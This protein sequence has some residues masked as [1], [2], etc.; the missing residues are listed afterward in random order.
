[1]VETFEGKRSARRRRSFRRQ[2][3]GGGATEVPAEPGAEGGGAEGG[4]EEEFVPEPGRCV[5]NCSIA[6]YEA[7]PETNNECYGKILTVS[8]VN[9][10]PP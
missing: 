6:T 8:T 3:G 7:N 10:I 4:G 1:M 9:G 5:N 2:E